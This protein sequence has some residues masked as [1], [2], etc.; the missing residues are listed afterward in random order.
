[1]NNPSGETTTVLVEMTIDAISS[2]AS[3]VTIRL[4]NGEMEQLQTGDGATKLQRELRLRPGTSVMTLSVD[5]P[6]EPEAK[7]SSEG[8]AL[9]ISDSLIEESAF[10][11]FR[12][13][14]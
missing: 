14:R 5:G 6:R 12:R 2:K 8:P 11:P 1:M 4:P 7:D 9:R 13:T 10:F 3:T